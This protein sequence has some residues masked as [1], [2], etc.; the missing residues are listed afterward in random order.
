MS[1]GG[2]ELAELSPCSCI[3]LCCP[4]QRGQRLARLFGQHSAVFIPQ[5]VA[6]NALKPSDG[7]LTEEFTI[8]MD[9]NCPSACDETLYGQAS[10][11][12]GWHITLC[13]TSRWHQNKSSVL[14]WPALAGLG[15]NGTFVLKS[16]AGFAQRD[17]SPC[18]HI[19]CC[20]VLGC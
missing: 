6:L 5:T 15:Q 4:N 12:T 9:C 11:Y 20:R 18:I 2:F 3:L 13:K 7:E 1:T 17:V 16:T 8:G 10:A 14:A 19:F